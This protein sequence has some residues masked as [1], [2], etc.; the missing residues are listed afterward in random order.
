MYGG[1]L[2]LTLFGRL[3]YNIGHGDEAK[4]TVWRDELFVDYYDELSGFDIA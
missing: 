2:R 3:L 4:D 1:A